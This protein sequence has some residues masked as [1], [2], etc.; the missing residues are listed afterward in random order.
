MGDH[1][2]PIHPPFDSPEFLDWVNRVIKFRHGPI[3]KLEGY[4]LL[5]ERWSV[6]ELR[7]IKRTNQSSNICLT[8]TEGLIPGL[9]EWIKGYTM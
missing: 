9:K 3:R 1:I 4:Y 8:A 6:K 7:K 5:R 2:I